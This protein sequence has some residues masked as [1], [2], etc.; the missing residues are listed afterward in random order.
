VLSRYYTLQQPISD[1]S[2]SSELHK[3]LQLFY[4]ARYE[5]LV[6]KRGLR[7]TEWIVALA[8]KRDDHTG[9]Q[10]QSGDLVHARRNTK[11]NPLA[12]PESQGTESITTLIFLIA[13]VVITTVV[14]HF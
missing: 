9:D 1:R 12:S 4:T 5:T 7:S 14:Q 3:A 11:D 10:P 8:G 13:L 6:S 2:H